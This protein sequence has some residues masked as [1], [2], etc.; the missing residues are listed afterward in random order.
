MC[1]GGDQENTIEVTAIWCKH[2]FVLEEDR[3]NKYIIKFAKIDGSD[4]L[5]G[6]SLLRT[7]EDVQGEDTSFIEGFHIPKVIIRDDDN[8]LRFCIQGMCSDGTYLYYK[9][10][11][12]DEEGRDELVKYNLKTGESI[13]VDGEKYGHGNDLT[14]NKNTGM[15]YMV[16]ATSS[17]IYI[18]RA[19]TLESVE[20]VELSSLVDGGNVASIAYNEKANQYV[21]VGGIYYTEEN[22]TVGWTY[23]YIYLVDENFQL[24]KKFHLEN[25]YNAYQGIDCDGDYIYLAKVD[26]TTNVRGEYVFIYDMGGNYIDKIEC[27]YFK[28]IEGIQRVGDVFYL[29]YANKYYGGYILETIPIK[30]KRLM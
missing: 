28:E 26:L 8:L 18:I 12:L 6:E 15:L 1:V 3:Q 9:I 5:E 17:K 23:P 25:D 22:N 14:Y 20:T 11:K 4:I 29:A 13:S 30:T 16:D 2:D 24:I 27:N 10:T 7:S 21:L 19:D